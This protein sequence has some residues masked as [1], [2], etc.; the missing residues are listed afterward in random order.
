MNECEMCGEANC[1]KRACIEALLAHAD[2]WEAEAYPAGEEGVRSS[3][4]I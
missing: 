2:Y 1:Q 4:K 3:G